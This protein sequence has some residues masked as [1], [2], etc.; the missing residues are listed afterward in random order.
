MKRK[1]C[2]VTGSRAEYGLLRWVMQGIRAS[3]HLELQVVATGMHLSEAFGY[4]YREIE[5]DG[6]TIDKRV[7]LQLLGDSSLQVAK[8]MSLGLAGFAEAFESLGPD[9]V[10]LLGDRFEIFSAAAAAMVSRI[11]LAHLH[12]GETTE[13]A[14]DE[15]IRHAVTKL[16]HLHFVAADEYRRRVIQLGEDPVRVFL[17]GGLGVDSILR[18]APMSRV[19]LEESLGFS[20]RPRNLLVT[21]HPAT[22]EIDAAADQMRELLMALSTLHDTGLIFTLPN[23]DPGGRAVT[24]LISD[25]VSCH[26]NACAFPSLGQSRYL[27]CIRQVD[28]VIGNSSSGL[29]EVP[30]FSK[31][32]VN[33][34]SR[35]R[36]RLKASS[37]IDCQPQCHAILHAIDAM[38]AP[39]F[40][41]QLQATKNPYGDGGASDKIVSIL[42]HIS[43]E[44]L[45]EKS[46]YDI[47]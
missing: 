19:S 2:V 34:G 27:S 18:L 37:V 6:F 47:V 9:L 40:Q 7:D 21:F 44:Y 36:G 46:F 31:G 1:I 38:Y 23:A 26:E 3:D 22:L 41:A 16:A 13:G 15:S 32:T 24:E 42:E 10:L 20:F 14:F 33:I 4:T 11:P 17:V 29:L 5:Q 43:F 25:F 30:S 12:G 8:S 28:G 45:L 35:Q 39:E